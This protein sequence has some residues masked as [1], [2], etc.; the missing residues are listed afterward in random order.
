MQKFIIE[1]NKKSMWEIFKK[2]FLSNGWEILEISKELNLH[3]GTI[4]RWISKEEV[5]PQ[6]FNDF[7]R[8]LNY[9]YK[10]NVSKKDEFKIM[11]QFFTPET[12]A[13]KLIKETINFIKQNY[14][15]N[16]NDY[17]FIE[18]AAGNG[19]F[20]KGI[21]SKYK[22]I[23]LDID[24]KEKNI[25]KADWLKYTP[26]SKLNIVIG[27]PPFGLRGQLALK[28]INH[29]ANFADF[30]AFILPPLFNSN[31]KGSPRLR[32]KNLS[33]VY[34]TEVK[35]IKFTYPSGDEVYVNSIFQIWTTKFSETVPPLAPPEKVSEW[36]NVYALSNGD[37]PS[38]KRNVKMIGE[39]DFYLPSTT[40]N[41][42]N[43]CNSFDELPHNR[44]YGIVAKKETQ[45]VKK[46]AQEINWSSVSFKS[47][48]GANNL[49]TQ[50]II[51]A[52]EKK[53]NKIYK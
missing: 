53:M 4:K 3:K 42:I 22:K 41:A 35:N 1:Y 33:L 8:L 14:G 12:E 5:P 24:P 36:I 19:S 15:V 7:N 2:D 16:L 6:Y 21:P 27:N 48:N 43:I 40:F 50:L 20:A 10:L 29:A 44:G 9:K 45:K 30:I 26:K 47:T 31:G 17:T 13:K 37:L 11:D 18:P 49:R 23:L 38:S 51:D 39:C 52:I 25:I 46:N 28:F 34:E 32:V